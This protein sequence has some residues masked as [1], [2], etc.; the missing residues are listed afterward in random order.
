MRDALEAA[1]PEAQHM[2]QREGHQHMLRSSF[3]GRIRGREG[4]VTPY[5]CNSARRC[6]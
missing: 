4:Q 3:R 2:S 1:I 5:G 6:C